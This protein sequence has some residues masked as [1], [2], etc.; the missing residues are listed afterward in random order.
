MVDEIK[1]FVGIDWASESHRACLLDSDGQ[2]V[3]ERDFTH[4]GTGLSELCSWLLEKTGAKYPVEKARGSAKKY[5]E[6]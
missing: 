6:F 2:C 5:T 4:D 3:G 1:W